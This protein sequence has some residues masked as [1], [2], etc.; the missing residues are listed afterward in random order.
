MEVFTSHCGMARQAAVGVYIS[1]MWDI[2]DTVG[3]E[4]RAL[5]GKPQAVVSLWSGLGHSD[6]QSLTQIRAM[7]AE[8]KRK[9]EEGKRE[10]AE[11]RAVKKTPPAQQAT[12]LE[13][14][15][16]SIK[17]QPR[18][19]PTCKKCG[20]PMKGH[21]C[22]HRPPRTKRDAHAHVRTEGLTPRVQDNGWGGND[23]VNDLD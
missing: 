9:K 10:R 13:H 4:Q 12:N 22:P 20:K 11:A 16:G 5:Y 15:P 3:A 21:E 19:P 14:G 8:E 2:A 1:S 6:S 7:D 23:P 18:K 17:K